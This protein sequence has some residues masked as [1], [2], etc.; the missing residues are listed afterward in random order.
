MPRMWVAGLVVG[1]LASRASAT[2]VSTPDSSPAAERLPVRAY[3]VDDGLAGDEVQQILQQSNGFLWI[4]TDSGLSRFDGARFV[5]Y[6]SRHGLPSPHVTG[7]AETAQGDLLVATTA[8]LARL[9]P[10]AT[11]ASKA[12]VPISTGRRQVRRA[13]ALLVDGPFA[14]LAETTGGALLRLRRSGDA[15]AVEPA[16]LASGEPVVG[17]TA[18][19]GGGPRG[20]WA[21]GAHGVLFRTPNGAWQR[22]TLPPPVAESAVDSLLVDHDGRLWIATAQGVFVAA[23]GAPLKPAAHVPTCALEASTP[24]L[25][26]GEICQLPEIAEAGERVTSLAA[27]QEGEIWLATT[28]RLCAIRGGRLHSFTHRNGLFDDYPVSLAEDRDGGLWVGSHD[29]G[30]VRIA[31]HGFVT[32]AVPSAPS[33][34][35]VTAQIL[36]DDKGRLLV[37]GKSRQL[38]RLLVLNS[39]GLVDDITPEIL[40][41]AGDPGRGRHQVLAAG[42][43]GQ[44]WLATAPGIWQFSLSGDVSGLRRAPGHF[45]P[46]PPGLGELVR[47]YRDTRGQ[48]WVWGLGS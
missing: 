2:P 19:A 1:L 26:S 27:S 33:T 30:L 29:H 8:G 35:F 6:D 45:S 17:I 41:K 40:A 47:L 38:G 44:L 42:P 21:A 34:V 5:N 15:F 28:Q 3:T 48:F 7:V 43:S 23:I 11:L 9:D 10:Q 32:F 16:R 14:W 24:V 4:A 39:D 20:V 36:E 12:F 13:A 46:A 37:W 31:Q 18:L 22:L 25:R